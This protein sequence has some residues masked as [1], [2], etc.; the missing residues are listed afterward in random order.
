MMPLSMAKE[1]ERSSIKKVGGI[2][3]TRQHLENLGFVVGTPITIITKIVKL[4][5]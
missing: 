3:E 1:G 2:G 4:L 5:Y